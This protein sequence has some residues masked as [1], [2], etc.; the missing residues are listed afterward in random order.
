VRAPAALAAASALNLPFG[1]LYAFSVFLKPLEALLGVGRAPMSFVF[2]LA[3]I[4]LTAGMVVAPSV[5]R[6]FPPAA[7]ALACGACSA[8]GLF[9]AASATSFPQFVLGYG[10]LFGLGAGIGFIVVQQ[11]VNQSVTTRSGLANG[12]VVSL[13]PLG[14]MLGA[15]L[16]G[17]TIEAYGIR[18]TLAGLGVTVFAGCALTALLLRAA[19]IRMHEP[20]VAGENGPAPQRTTFFLLAGVFFLAAAAG[21]M[22][23]SQAAGIVQAYGGKT[24]LAVVATTLITGAVGAAR[25]AGGWLT[26]RFTVPRVAMGGQ[27]FACCGA[28]ILSVWPGALVAVPALAMIAMGYGVISGLTAA[29]IA[30][31]W[32]KNLFGRIAGRLYI[33]WCVAAVT[34]PILAGWLYDRTAGYGTAVAIAGGLNL[35]AV[36]L[37]VRLP[38]P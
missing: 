4:T 22:V 20:S 19:D 9:L 30:R 3:T 37:A 33:A 6:R 27:L 5:Y 26:D 29:A 8:A 10:V 1:T 18:A 36:V 28:L 23:M 12:Y 7:I 32:G 24:G 11:G 25:I 15:P 35:L 21:L 34:L 31:Y 38:K 17:W 16:F 2:A 14:A 13:Y